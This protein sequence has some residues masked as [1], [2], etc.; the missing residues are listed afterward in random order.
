M[1]THPPHGTNDR[2]DET[3]PRED[4]H[5]EDDIVSLLEENARLRGL[6]IKLSDI[7]LRSVAERR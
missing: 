4:E 1:G 7:V 2:R 6:V 5:A 3:R